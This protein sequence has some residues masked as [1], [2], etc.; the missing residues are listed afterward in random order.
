MLNVTKNQTNYLVCTLSEVV[1]LTGTPYY[2]LYLE[3]QNTNNTYSVICSD[4]SSATTRYN[5]L[6]LI[7]NTS[8]N[9]TGGTINLPVGEYIYK[10]YEQTS[11]TNLLIA[12]TTSL[13]ERGLLFVNNNATVI[14]YISDDKII[15]F[16][17]DEQ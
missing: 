3:H 10:I 11:P 1:T 4:V 17:I 8:Q 6:M 7:D 5:K 16:K 13:L 14:D 2:L 15:T 12:N 9:L